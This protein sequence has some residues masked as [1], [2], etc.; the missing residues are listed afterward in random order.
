MQNSGYN[1]LFMR[2]VLLRKI[3]ST[4][5]ES[6]IESFLPEAFLKYFNR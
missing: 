4:E 6:N 1:V 2:T 5:S 3:Y